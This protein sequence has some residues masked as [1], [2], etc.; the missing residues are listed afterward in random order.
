MCRI[1]RSGALALACVLPLV[2]T[3]A[4]MG[5]QG[6]TM[7]MGD[8][9]SNWRELSVNYAVTSRDAFGADYTFMRSDDGTITREIAEANYTRLLYRANLPDA[10]ANVWFLVGLGAIR[11]SGIDGEEAVATPGVQVDYETTRVYF[12]AMGRLY[13]AS[14]V[15]ND[16]GALRAGFSFFEAEYDELQPWF[17]VEARRMRG[18]SD[19]IEV[20]PLLR[21]ITRNYFIEAGVNNM[22]QV[23]FNFMYIF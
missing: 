5:Y 8:F 7:A 6:S 3:A 16:Y 1:G 22:R 4:P 14:G 13:R 12:S 10:Q 17:I 18:L 9:S 21:V 19:E 20:T 2:A 23:R 15:N 11:G